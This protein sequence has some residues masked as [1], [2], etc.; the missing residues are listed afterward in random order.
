M[1]PII[2][3]DVDGVL[4]TPHTFPAF[5]P[6]AVK[7]F[8][9]LIKEIRPRIVVSSSWRYNI[10]PSVLTHR[11]FSYLL[12]THGITALGADDVISNTKL[13]EEINGRENQIKDWLNRNGYT[14]KWIAIDDLPL[15]LPESN[16]IRTHKSVGFDEKALR[17]ALELLS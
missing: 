10:K 13:D 17:K 4:N 8:N 16:F 7:N 1:R 6:Q 11:G 14:G 5:E 9:N 2:F 12:F 15:A 3:L